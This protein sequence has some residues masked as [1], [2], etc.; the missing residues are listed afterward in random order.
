VLSEL[1]VLLLELLVVP[2]EL[3]SLCACSSV[4]CRVLAN[5]WKTVVRSLSLIEAIEVLLAE[6][7]VLALLVLSLVELVEKLDEVDEVLPMLHWLSNWL[8]ASAVPTELTMMSL[9]VWRERKNSS[10]RS[11]HGDQILYLRIF[12]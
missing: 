1:L 12:W 8:S 10:L 4:A 6:P 9:L 7:V 2:L 5:C 11:T 3:P